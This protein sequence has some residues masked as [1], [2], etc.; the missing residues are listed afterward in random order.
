MTK[1]LGD[2]ARGPSRNW[3]NQVKVL[4]V[5]VA[6]VFAVAAGAND[7]SSILAGGRQVS[8]FRPTTAW[9]VL[10]AAVAVGPILIGTH[11]AV[12][13]S[14]GLVP[15]S[16]PGSKRAFIVAVLSAMLVVLGLTRVGVST[17]LTL[18]LLGAIAGA[19][20]GAGMHVDLSRFVTVVGFG[21]AA[22]VASAS[23]AYAFARVVLPMLRAQD[24]GRRLRT[25]HAV[26]FGAQCLAYATN[27]GQ[28]VLALLIVATGSTARGRVVLPR[29]DIAL[30]AVPF[31]LGVLLGV[32]RVSAKLGRGV[33]AV[34]L[35]HTVVAEAVSTVLSLSAGLVGVPLTMSQSVAGALVGAGASEGIHRVRWAVAGRFVGAWVLTVPTSMGIAAAASA[36]A[37]RA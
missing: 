27:G 19:G 34:R 13:L 8:A 25:T 12:T 17:S 33:L 28:K 3:G 37:R 15:F 10:V 9:I 4:L 18:S 24:L 29:L 32:R 1:P 36:I 23:L 14:R 2:R 16:G 30:A 21:F 5:A 7:G 20:L 22:P 35:R 31:G 11:V 6:A 26:T